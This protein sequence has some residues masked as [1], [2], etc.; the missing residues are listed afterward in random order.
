MDPRVAAH[1]AGDMSRA[2]ISPRKRDRVMAAWGY[3]DS[4]SIL[5]RESLAVRESSAT[6]AIANEYRCPSCD[7]RY[8]LERGDDREGFPAGTT[9]QSIPET[10]CCPDC[11]VRDKIDFVPVF[12]AGR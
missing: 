5:A 10:W 11:G 2:N 6:N 1:F 4:S 8:V 3:E 12:V 9:W 7:Y